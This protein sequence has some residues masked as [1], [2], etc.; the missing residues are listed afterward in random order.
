MSG[1][2]RREA[3]RAAGG[4][5]LEVCKNVKMG[6][7]AIGMEGIGADLYGT[8]DYPATSCNDIKKNNPGASSQPYKRR[9]APIKHAGADTG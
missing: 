9:P 8:K 2:V 6:W 7:E 4:H 3:R 1:V 5:K